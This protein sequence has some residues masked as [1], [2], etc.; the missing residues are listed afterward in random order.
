L[1]SLNAVITVRHLLRE[2]KQG[3]TTLRLSFTDY[4]SRCVAF[5]YRFRQRVEAVLYAAPHAA[6]GRLCSGPRYLPSPVHTPPPYPA[7]RPRRL[8]RDAFTRALVREHQLTASDLILPVF[9]LAGSGI[10]QEVKAMPG[11]QRLSLDRLLPVAEECVRLGIPV[12][13]LFPVIEPD[14]KTADGREALNPEGLV[15]TVV[16]A[17]KQRFPE[18]GLMTDVALDPFTTHGQDGLPDADPQEN[19][20]ILNDETVAV[21][22]QQALMQAQAGVDIVAPSDMMDGRIGAIRSALEAQRLIHTRIM[23]YSAKYASAF[24][25]PFRDAVGSAGNLGKG[26]KKVYQMD[27]ANSDEAL[28]EV[29]LDIAEGADMVMVKPG[30]PY[31]DIVRRVKDEFHV[32]TF[33]YQVSG[34]YAM[35]KA[36]AANGWLDHDAVMMESLLAF[37]RAGADGVLSYF[38]LEAAR[39]L[40]A[41]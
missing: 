31:L 1:E 28:R 22:T 21:L 34:E 41:S 10:T 15:P 32:P 25:G 33:A 30:M 20:Y 13:A 23:A 39:L 37:K 24:Y 8:R 7:S 5:C 36:A 27:P 19:G 12:M 17:L 3:T 18:L 6:S 26:N 9:V 35:L 2:E 38:A 14:R 29:A 40:K 11:V 4:S 16:R